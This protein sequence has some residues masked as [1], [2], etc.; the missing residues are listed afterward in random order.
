MSER[1]HGP[2]RLWLCIA[3]R[4]PN[5]LILFDRRV[6]TCL[7]LLLR[8]LLLLL[9]SALLL[10]LILLLVLLLFLLPTSDIG[11]TSPRCFGRKTLP[12]SG[13]RRNI[14]S[15]SDILLSSWPCVPI[16]SPVVRSKCG[17]QIWRQEQIVDP[18]LAEGFV[19]PGLEVR[20]SCRP[21]ISRTSQL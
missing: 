21:Y 4:L 15:L 14:K 13:L 17:E 18:L 16:A 9:S 6:E 7:L 12:C 20:T 2:C 1:R 8:I 11:Q 5:T 10:L 3:A 19:L